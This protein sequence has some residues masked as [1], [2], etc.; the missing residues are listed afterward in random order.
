MNSKSTGA[1]YWLNAW[2]RTSQIGMMEPALAA[3][4][5]Y[6]DGDAATQ[7]EKAAGVRGPSGQPP[8]CGGKRLCG[9][10]YPAVGGHQEICDRRV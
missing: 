6:A 1:G 9:Y 10:H 5:M 8:F 7:K 2:R 3:K 4:I